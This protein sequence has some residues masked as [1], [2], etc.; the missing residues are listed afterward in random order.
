MAGPHVGTGVAAAAG[1]QG[2]TAASDG[3]DG[4]GAGTQAGP[5]VR[6]VV[7]AVLGSHEGSWGC[8]D[9][10]HAPGTQVQGKHSG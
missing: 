2:C 7:P 5:R 8:L 3:G 9:E 4:H 10:H 6:G 1:T